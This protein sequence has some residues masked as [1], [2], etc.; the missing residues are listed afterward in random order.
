MDN[1]LI[2]IS[3]EQFKIIKIM[4]ANIEKPGYPDNKKR[5]HAAAIRIVLD[6]NNS[7]C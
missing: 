6:N 2:L 7:E 5:S 1:T 4:L 3:R